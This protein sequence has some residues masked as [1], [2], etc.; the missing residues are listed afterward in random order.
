MDIRVIDNTDLLVPVFIKTF[1]GEPWNERWSAE[2]ASKALMEIYENS[3]FYALAAFDKNEVIGAILGTI[4]TYDVSQ[5]C[6]IDHLFVSPEYRR[7]RVASQ[8]YQKAI[9][10][11]KEKGVKGAFFTTLRNTPAYE[12]YIRHGA[13][14][15]ET[16]AVMYHPFQ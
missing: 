10:E 6:Y 2:S 8:L 3:G 11:L 15:L 7:Q 1:N 16:G 13:I 4:K 5:V 12:F 14:D 9:K